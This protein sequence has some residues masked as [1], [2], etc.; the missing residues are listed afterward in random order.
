M[1]IETYV[2]DIIEER[3]KAPIVRGVFYLFSQLYR[4][5]VSL[6]NW[7]YDREW[8]KAEKISVPVISVGNIITGGTGKTPLIHKLCEELQ[9]AGKVAILTRGFRSKVEH[10]GEIICLSQ[11]HSFS[12]EVCGD[13]PYWLSRR[14]PDVKVWVGKDRVASAK[15]ASKDTDFILLDDGM[16]FRSLK[17]DLEIVVIDGEDPLGKGHFLPRG[18][19]RDSPK[20]LKNADLIVMNHTRDKAHYE[21][22]K[23]EL[24]SYT[25]APMVGMRF[26]SQNDFLK[27]APV[28]VFCGVGKPDRFLNQIKEVGGNILSSFILLD[29]HP[30]R[31]KD[32]EIFSEKCKELGAKYLICTEKDAVKLPDELNCSLPI[33]PIEVRLEVVAGGEHW[34]AILNKMRAK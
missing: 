8:L 10:S 7:V 4:F 13:E 22:V 6:R 9:S 21:Q 33:K 28:G 15:R 24:S 25:S 27:D 5:A 11:E 29:H 19:L 17:R 3:R 30:M 14:L 1:F 12:P 26:V 16:Q 34:H 32:L 31:K 20:R 18:L 2:L 23:K